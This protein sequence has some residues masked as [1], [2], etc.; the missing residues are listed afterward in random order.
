MA[1]NFEG[2]HAGATKQKGFGQKSQPRTSCGTFS[3]NLRSNHPRS[4]P[5][6]GFGPHTI[7]EAGLE[8]GVFQGTSIIFSS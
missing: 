2:R 4:A 7:R 3:P 5:S 6:R 8:Q 1:D